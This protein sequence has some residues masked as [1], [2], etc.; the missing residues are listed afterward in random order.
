MPI[1]GLS[2]TKYY[3]RLG[4]NPFAITENYPRSDGTVLL[5]ENTSYKITHPA[6]QYDA[7]MG[8]SLALSGDGN[9]LIVGMPDGAWYDDTSFENE[10]PAWPGRV[11]AYY[12]NPA[13]PT[14][15]TSL[16]AVQFYSLGGEEEVTGNENIGAVVAM[17]RDGRWIASSNQES[18]KIEIHGPDDK[19]TTI[20]T[21]TIPGQFAFNANGSR[22]V[23][24]KPLGGPA[25][26]HG[27]VTVYGI[28]ESAPNTEYINPYILGNLLNGTN[29]NDNFGAEVCINDEGNIIGVGIPGAD[30]A[31]SNLGAVKMYKLI[32]STWTQIGQSIGLNT[33]EKVTSLAM[34]G[35]GDIICIGSAFN[36]AINTNEPTGD[37]SVYKFD[38]SN[39]NLLG[40]KIMNYLNTTVQIGHAVDMSADG[41]TIVVSN[42]ASTIT[43]NLLNETVVVYRY[44][45]SDWKSVGSFVGPSNTAQNGYS[46]AISSDGKTIVAGAPGTN[47]NRGEVRYFTLNV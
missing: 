35:A 13:A 47:S 39:W 3:E 17:S 9:N 10:A 46:V 33:E 6:G 15:W 31:G 2:T 44:N 26:A 20:D 29:D 43:S 41:Y 45:G 28:R 11:Q 14:T 27:R 21:N 24:G 22:L 19:I 8:T 23:V 12:K 38:G 4:V 32:G 18:H 16:G 42:G 40:H 37:V 1:N 30:L 25:T 36:Q 5:T 34:N 7:R